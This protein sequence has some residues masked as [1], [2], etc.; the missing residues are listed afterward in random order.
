MLLKISY[1][2]GCPYLT[3]NVLILMPDLFSFREEEKYSISARQTDAHDS[4]LSSHTSRTQLFLLLPKIAAAKKQ[5]NPTVVTR[6][7]VIT[8]PSTNS[9]NSEIHA[10]RKQHEGSSSLSAEHVA[11]EATKHE[12][13]QRE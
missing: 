4:F 6:V 7:T 5:T 8:L 3:V 13:P 11:S 1:F 2:N 10:Y 12:T 9:Q